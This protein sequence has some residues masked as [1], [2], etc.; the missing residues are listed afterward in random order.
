MLPGGTVQHSFKPVR[1]VPRVSKR[2][3]AVY[4]CTNSTYC[5]AYCAQHHAVYRL[6]TYR[7][8]K[9]PWDVEAVPVHSA[10]K[11]HATHHRHNII[12]PYERTYSTVLQHITKPKYNCPLCFRWVLNSSIEEF[13]QIPPSDESRCT[14]I[15]MLLGIM[16]YVWHHRATWALDGCFYRLRI[17]IL[18]KVA[19]MREKITPIH[20][21]SSSF[22]VVC[23][24]HCLRPVFT[25]RKKFQFPKKRLCVFHSC[26]LRVL[27]TK[28]PVD[29]V[30]SYIFVFL[31]ACFE[32]NFAHAF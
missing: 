16:S 2:V 32:K 3:C 13:D 24:Q 31:G 15:K 7:P 30:T 17:S 28:L 21:V 29:I 4:F 18:E 27:S 6:Y 8:T 1:A 10:C 5:A 25:C 12:T 22:P 20:L 14:R 26:L 9:G 19:H 23:C 11:A